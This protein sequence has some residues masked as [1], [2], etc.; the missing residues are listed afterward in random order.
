MSDKYFMD[1]HKL[2]WHLDRVVQWSADRR[3]VPIYVEIG[4]VG[5]C[6]NHCVFCGVDFDM[7]KGRLMPAEVICDR[8]REMGEL[9]VRSVLFSGEGEPTLHPE[10]ARIVAT[11]RGAGLDVAMSTNGNVGDA[12]LWSVL[13]PHLTWIRFSVDAGTPET[14]AAVHRIPAP[15]FA[16]VT[17]NVRLALETKRRL[18]LATTI[19][20]QFV[21]LEENVGDL[22]SFLRIFTELGV[23]YVTIKPFSH[24]PKMLSDKDVDYQHPL[25][26]RV[27]EL[28]AR[29]QGVNGTHVNFRRAAAEVYSRR[30]VGCEHCYS[31]PF[32]GHINS[33]GRFHSCG[34][35]L[36]DPRFDCGDV[37]KSSMQEILFGAR[38]RES[39]RFGEEELSLRDECRINCRMARI[40]EYLAV[41][42]NPPP[43]VNFI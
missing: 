22:E 11:A 39:I 8:L 23:D 32:W 15:T 30:E 27:G 25:L 6:N 36:S 19:G 40:N 33:K 24:H 9:G 3:I 17:Q 12:A 29:F 16:K 31:L 38:R 5:Y 35:F 18:G 14:Y 1:S 10:L 34:V 37:L 7:E 2:H 43:H 26:G 13:L 4:L 41:M 20:A 28:V 21:L 42:V